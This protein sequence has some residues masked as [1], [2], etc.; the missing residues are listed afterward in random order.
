LV[1]LF[2]FDCHVPKLFTLVPSSTGKWHICLRIQDSFHLGL[3][4]HTL[5]GTELISLMDVAD[6]FK[7]I[8]D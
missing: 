6:L 2:Q 4:A 8:H 3:K 7:D 1:K 5:E